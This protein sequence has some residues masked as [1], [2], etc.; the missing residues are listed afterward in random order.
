[1]TPAWRIEPPS[2]LR[3][4]RAASITS[5]EPASIEPTGAPSPFDR[6]HITVVAWAA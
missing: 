4:T 5:A 3:S 2:R 6:Q 1:M